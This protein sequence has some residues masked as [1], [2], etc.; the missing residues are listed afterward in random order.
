MSFDPRLAKVIPGAGAWATHHVV[1]YDGGDGVEG[2]G[3]L[4]LTPERYTAVSRLTGKALENQPFKA[5]LL[6]LLA[7]LGASEDHADAVAHHAGVAS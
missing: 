7:P 1:Q 6:F 4:M 2:V 5:C 3:F